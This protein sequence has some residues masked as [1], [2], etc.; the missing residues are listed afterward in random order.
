MP[1]KET[2]M[3][4]HVL[5]ALL[6]VASLMPASAL[7]AKTKSATSQAAGAGEQ[8]AIIPVFTLHGPIAESPPDDMMLFSEPQA[9]LRDL[10]DRMDKAAKDPA[11]KA[12][13]FLAEDAEAGPG[14]IA[15]LR[16]AMKRIRDAGKEIYV[17]SD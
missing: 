6:F 15:D 13:V 16:Q 3:R 17:H 10:V 8:T 11:V 7:A 14:Q 12:V 2:L 9:S 1:H 5:A 4:L